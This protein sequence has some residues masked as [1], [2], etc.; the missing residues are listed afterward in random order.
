MLNILSLGTKAPETNFGIRTRTLILLR[1]IAVVGQSAAVLFVA[2]GL[3]F[4]LPLAACLAVI[5]ASAWLN[6]FLGFSL[7]S[8][9][10]AT[11]NYTLAQ[12]IF[13][14][15]QMAMLLGLTGGLA[16]PFVILLGVPVVV[17]I[18]ALPVRSTAILGV[19]TLSAAIILS[20]F[21]LPLPWLEGQRPHIPD[22]FIWGQF[23][24]LVT[25]TGFMAIYVWRVSMEGRRMQA[26]L[27]ATEA[28]LAKEA[29][30]SALGGLAAAVAHELG[31][32]LGTIALVARE[33]THTLPKESELGEDAQ[34]LVEQAGRC[35]EILSKLSDSGAENDPIHARHTLS[36]LLEEIASPLRKSGIAITVSAKE[37]GGRTDVKV[38]VLRRQPEIMH[39]LG[40]FA[41]NAADFARSKVDLSGFWDD[42]WIEI[43]I[44]DDGPG[45][46]DSIREKLGEPYVTTR[47]GGDSQGHGGM[48]LGIFIATTLIERTDGVIKLGKSDR[49]G[50]A[51]VRVIWPRVNVETQTT[52]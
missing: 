7:N 50:G 27:T 38:P 5:S 45:F 13:D 34:L 4:T 19:L 1:W 48:G 35:R 20:K 39:A 52:I 14:L 21:S 26:A 11:P 32:P 16:N 25:T 8:G 43:V 40:A 18:T 33:M 42:N 6:I 31:T 22:L 46:S 51:M 23:T 9:R 36:D 17:A 44:S 2:F 24:A 37:K 28:V 3:H 15:V 12:L 30:L 49:L 41:D 47:A 29:R 10:Y